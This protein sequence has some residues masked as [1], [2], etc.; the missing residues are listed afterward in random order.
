MRFWVEFY[1]LQYPLHMSCKYLARSLTILLRIT[2]RVIILKDLQWESCSE[3]LSLLMFVLHIES[4]AGKH[5]NRLRW[6]IYN[7]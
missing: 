3:F 5:D 2:K 7:I 1:L 6:V 4:S